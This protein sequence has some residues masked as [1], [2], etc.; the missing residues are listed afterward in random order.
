MPA[1]V[2]KGCTGPDV[3]LCQERLNVWNYPCD[4]DGVF[5]KATETAV[6]EFQS[7]HSL[8]PDGIVGNAT[9][10]VLLSSPSVIPSPPYDTLSTS[11]LLEVSWYPGW[12]Y[13]DYSVSGALAL[14]ARASR[15][16]PANV[17]WR[18]GLKTDTV[19]CVFVG[20]VVG[21]VYDKTANWTADAWQ[22]F[23]VPV[24]HPWGM[25]EECI[26]SG[27]GD[28]YLGSPQANC[29]YVAQGWSG[30]VDGKVVP[31]SKGHQWLQ[32]GPD[33]MVEATTWND[34]DGDGSSTDPGAV[35]W[36]HRSWVDQVKRYDEV[37]LVV[38][39]TP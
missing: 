5:G 7:D 11:M 29:W 19:C 8:V 9:W 28:A 21:C 13:T 34:E 31:T 1:T 18:K 4:V 15:L 35:A 26:A 24:D 27:I 17:V 10:Q 33:L 20:G 22:L 39:R 16:A 6:I 38:L 37:R 25:V 12:D 2:Y 32:W 14:V 3:S 30:L 23:M 36:R